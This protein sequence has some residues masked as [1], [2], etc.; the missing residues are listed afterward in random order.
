MVKTQI[1]MHWSAINQKIQI[2]RDFRVFV[3]CLIPEKENSEIP[4]IHQKPQNTYIWCTKYWKA[5]I[6][7]LIWWFFEKGF[8]KETFSLKKLFIAKNRSK[9]LWDFL[10][11]VYSFSEESG[12][13]AQFSQ[14]ILVKLGSFY[15]AKPLLTLLPFLL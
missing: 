7:L 1:H 6:A 8:L 2:F 10:I 14:E 5:K 15:F 11:K 13:L 9:I 12:N 4:E 3:L